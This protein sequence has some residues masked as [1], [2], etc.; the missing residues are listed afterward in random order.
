MNVREFTIIH[1]IAGRGLFADRR[2]GK[3]EVMEYYYGSV[4]YEDL[5]G[6]PGNMMVYGE[7][8]MVVTVAC[9]LKR[10]IKVKYKRQKTRGICMRR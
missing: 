2:I 10:E 5:L 9:F 1:K 7:E 6:N 3:E 4:V 8:V